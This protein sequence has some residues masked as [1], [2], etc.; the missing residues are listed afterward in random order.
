L[1]DKTL[2]ANFAN[3]ARARPIL[4]LLPDGLRQYCLQYERMLLADI[5]AQSG[6]PNITESEIMDMVPSATSKIITALLP[7]A[8]E[9]AV[10]LVKKYL[11][12]VATSGA[13]SAILT[14]LATK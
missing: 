3:A 8:G 5:R 1:V 6:N 11:P 12:T 7:V 9:I 14:Y 10:A 13:V 4:K 2:L